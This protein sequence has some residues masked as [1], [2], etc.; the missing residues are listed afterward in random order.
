MKKLQLKTKLLAGAVAALGISSVTNAGPITAKYLGATCIA[1]TCADLG[2]TMAGVVG[3]TVIAPATNADGGKTPGSDSNSAN[4]ILSY[5]IT[6]SA[7]KP[8]SDAL[9]DITITELNNEFDFYWGS[10]DIGNLVRFY[11]AGN[12]TASYNGTAAYAAITNDPKFGFGKTDGYFSFSGDFDEV[13]LSANNVSFEVARAVPEP[14]TLALLGLGL[15]GLG[16]ARRR[17]KA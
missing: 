2:S 6:S 13:V 1:A 16:A 10:I 14:G 17:Q 7:G 11:S 12:L 15:A 3:G 8:N 5:N 9:N 4:Q